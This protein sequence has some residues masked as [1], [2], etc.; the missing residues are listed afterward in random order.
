MDINTRL[1]EAQGSGDLINFAK[2]V[3]YGMFAYL[4]I[5]TDVV[6]VL[7][8]LTFL[9]MFLGVVKA[10]RLGRRFKFKKLLWGLVTKLSV[11]IIP[12]ILAFM[13][14]GLDYDFTWFVTAILNILVLSEGF[15]C[16]SNIISI[17]DKKEVNNEDYITLLLKKIRGGLAR[18]I[19]KSLD[20]IPENDDKGEEQ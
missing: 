15:S 16:I 1:M 19:N 17:K 9:D 10:L 4:N 8:V 14:K 7:F 6:F 13:G 12:V 11:L 3:M 18:L 20:A 5:N 2:G